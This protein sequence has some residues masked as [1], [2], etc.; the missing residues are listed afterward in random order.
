M[1]GS[2]WPSGDYTVEARQETRCLR[3]LSG[4]GLK[5]QLEAGA[6]PSQPSAEASG[7]CRTQPQ[8]SLLLLLARLVAHARELSGSICW[9]SW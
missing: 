4:E 6:V 3:G 7:L 2:L 1:W 8:D 9:V 5:S